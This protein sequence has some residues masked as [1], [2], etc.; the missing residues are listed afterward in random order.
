MIVWI[1]ILHLCC[2]VHEVSLKA[3][4]GLMT[5]FIVHFDTACDYT[6]QFTIIYAHTHTHRHTHIHQCAQSCLHHH[7]LVVASNGRHSLP[8]DFCTVSWP[9]LP[10]FES[11]SSKWLDTSSPL[12]NCN[13]SKLKSKLCYIMT[14]IQLV[15]LPW[16]QAPFWA[17]SHIFVIV[18]QV[19]ICWWKRACLRSHYLA[20]AAV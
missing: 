3:G 8:L 5:W 1:Y 19:Q 20:M 15:S 10:A 18:I 6:L 7:C 2:H 14:D 4:F 16:C 13:K 12:I 9:Q 17:T 11:H